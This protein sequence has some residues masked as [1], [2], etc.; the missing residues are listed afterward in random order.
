VRLRVEFTLEPFTEGAPGQHVVTALQQ[1]RARGITADIGPFGTVMEGEHHVVLHAIEPMVTA[2]FAHGATNV[3]MALSKVQAISAEG[4]AFLAAVEPVVRAT[5]GT[6]VE[7]DDLRDGDVPVWWQ[8][9]LVAGVRPAPAA[10]GPQMLR[11]ALDRLI[12]QVEDEM[13]GPLDTLSR[14]AKQRAVRLLDERGA[15]SVRGSVEEVADT[16]GVSRVTV[17]NYLKARHR[18]A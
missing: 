8:G 12:T 9:E 18:S 17:Y 15:F 7:V 10:D 11:G 14:E 1:L 6:V 2:A 16:M 5:G 13:G 4:S 3:S